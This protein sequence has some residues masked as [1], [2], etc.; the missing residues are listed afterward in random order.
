MDLAIAPE[1]TKSEPPL[2]EIAGPREESMVDAAKLF[3]ARRGIQVRVEGGGDPSDPGGL[4][5]SGGM[6]PGPHAMLAGPTFEEWLAS[7]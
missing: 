1:F 2:P 5:E 7:Q 4:Y 6:L 3:V